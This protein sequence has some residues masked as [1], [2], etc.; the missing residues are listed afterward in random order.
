MATRKEPGDVIFF[1]IR[2]TVS[3]HPDHVAVA[4]SGPY[5]GSEARRVG[6]E[7]HREAVRADRKALLIDVRNVTGRVPGIFERFEIG[8]R[9]AAHY[10]AHDPRIRLAV[11][12]DE[13]M[14]H[15]ERF[16]E[17]VARNRGADARVFTDETLALDWLLGRR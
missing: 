14:I 9:T 6:E 5:S 2:T 7:A 17:L 1:R 8:V 13:P 12:G 4:C 10:R 16:G 15:P 3:V 11:L